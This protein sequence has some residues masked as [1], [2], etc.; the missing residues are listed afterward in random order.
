MIYCKISTSILRRFIR[1]TPVATSYCFFVACPSWYCPPCT[2]PFKIDTMR[3]C[4]H[5]RGMRTYGNRSSFLFG[6][7][8]EVVV[9]HGED[10]Q[11]SNRLRLSLPIIYK[12]LTSCLTIYTSITVRSTKLWN[13][14]LKMKIVWQPDQWPRQL[15]SH[16]RR[17]SLI[18]AWISNHVT[19]SGSPV[20]WNYSSIPRLK[21][22]HRVGEITCLCWDLSC[23]MWVV[24]R[25][26]MD[27]PYAASTTIGRCLWTRE[28][29]EIS[30][31]PQAS[32][33]APKYI[34]LVQC[35]YACLE[36]TSMFSS[37]YDRARNAS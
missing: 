17:W 22:L 3:K 7:R 4:F 6:T 11:Y 32:V 37:Q 13:I 15:S 10:M 20:E 28:C 30:Q 31:L 14:C 29:Q 2:F 25:G 5:W 27:S 34:F 16:R 33:T 12:R 19:S 8:T 23:V 26:P 18:T 35:T 1:W 9:P 36:R 21:R 24:T